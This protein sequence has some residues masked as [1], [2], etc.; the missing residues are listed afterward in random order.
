M[1]GILLIER[2]E[3]IGTS[4]QHIL[5]NSKSVNPQP[6]FGS[7][8]KNVM[9]KIQVHVFRQS[10]RRANGMSSSDRKSESA[11]PSSA[12]KR[13]DVQQKSVLKAD[14]CVEDL[15]EE[16][17]VALSKRVGKTHS[18]TKPI[19]LKCSMPHSRKMVQDGVVDFTPR[20]FRKRFRIH[21]CNRLSIS[22]PCRK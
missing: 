3:G 13:C 11:R 5:S 2:P 4:E 12:V 17:T 8:A 16:E 22:V 1:C 9:G 14:V 19:E 21:F 15:L 20:R 7:V 10:K 18:G 6:E